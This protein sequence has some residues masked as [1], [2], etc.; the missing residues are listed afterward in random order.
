MKYLM[1]LQ[2]FQRLMMYAH[3]ARLMIYDV[4]NNKERCTTSFVF[5]LLLHTAP[6]VCYAQNYEWCWRMNDLGKSDG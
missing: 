6:E 1:Q 3:R 4:G 2:W 5:L